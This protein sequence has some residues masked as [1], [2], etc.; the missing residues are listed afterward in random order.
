MRQEEQRVDAGSR[1][2]DLDVAEAGYFI[3]IT[4]GDELI[5]ANG[6]ALLSQHL[7]YPIVRWLGKDEVLLVETRTEAKT[8]NAFVVDL[9][10]KVLRSFCIG[11]GVE[12][13]CVLNEKL[14]VGY[15]D[16]GVFGSEGPNNSGL[17]VFDKQGRLEFAFPEDQQRYIYDCYCLCPG[18]GSKVLFHPYDT[19]DLVELDVETLIW[20]HLP[21][22]EELHGSNAISLVGPQV[23]FHSPY[24]SKNCLFLWEPSTGR[25]SSAGE[26]SN[27]LRGLSRG[28]FLSIGDRGFTIVSP[29]DSEQ[30]PT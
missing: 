1:I 27:R 10:G 30:A 21:T 3:A 18:A 11:D 5:T 24:A 25:I 15:F 23:L 13:V 16:E 14:V 26:H 4:E 12:D 29:L 28:R 19:F 17:A 7:R 8:P 9:E 22:P 2:M 6:R 20:S